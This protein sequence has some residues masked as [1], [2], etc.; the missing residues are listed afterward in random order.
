MRL[1]R[2][3][4]G[5]VKFF[6]S[7]LSKLHHTLPEK[8]F[9]EKE[10]VLSL[11][12]LEGKFFAIL[13]KKI[14]AGLLKL[15]STYPLEPSLERNIKFGNCHVLWHWEKMFACLWEIQCRGNQ[16]CI[17]RVRRNNSKE[18]FFGRHVVSLSLLDFKW[19]N[20]GFIKFLSAEVIEA[21]FYL[22]IQTFWE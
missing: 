6:P 1:K 17:L 2:F 14:F 18:A 19:K 21:A 13:W 7:G 4:R 8:S 15:L 9:F 16:I 22:S 10:I 12:N 5:F 11:S 20:F 3:F